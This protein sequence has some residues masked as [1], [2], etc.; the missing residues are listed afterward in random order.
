MS[1]ACGLCAVNAVYTAGGIA[2]WIMGGFIIT[3]FV[4][5]AG[6]Y[7]FTNIWPSKK[8]ARKMDIAALLIFGFFVMSTPLFIV[9][10]ISNLTS[11]L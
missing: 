8:W 1:D 5:Y 4:L 3:M 7:V 10:M 9:I 6:R 11:W 2:W